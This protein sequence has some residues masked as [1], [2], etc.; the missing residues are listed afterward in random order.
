MPSIEPKTNWIAEQC[1]CEGLRRRWHSY[2]PKKVILIRVNLCFCSFNIFIFP[3]HRFYWILYLICFVLLPINAPLE[4][5]DDSVQAAIFVV[6]SLRYLIVL[7]VAW[8]VQSAH[9][10]WGLD[11]KH[12]PS[13][14]N[15]IFLV[16]KSYWPQYHYLLPFDYQTGEFGNYGMQKYTHTRI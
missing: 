6:F 10:I 4:Y 16:T 3:I 12:K 5:W 15:M 14:S 11:K 2:V 9:F 7:N 1:R 13:D 8:M